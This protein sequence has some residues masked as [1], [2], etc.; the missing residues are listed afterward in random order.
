MRINKDQISFSRWKNFKFSFKRAHSHF[1]SYLLNRFRWHYYPRW[2]LVSRFPSHLDIE[3]SSVCNMQCPMCFTIT[4]DFKTKIDK[5]FMSFSLFKKIV[6][7]A[8][9][10]KTYSVRI[11]HRGEPFIHPEVIDFIKYAKENGIKEVSSL[12]NILALSPSLFEQ[13]MKAGLDWLTISFDGLGDTYEAIRKPAKFKESYEK[14]KEYKRIKEEAKSYK[15]V[16]KIQSIWP[17]IRDYAEEYIKSFEPYVDTI[18]SNPLIDY[19]HKDDPAKIEYWEDFDCP[20]PYQR[21]TI[22]SNGLVPYCH[23]DEF[24]TSIVGDIKKETIYN[25]WNGK[26]MKKVREAHKRNNG[27]T[28]LSACKH[29]FL[30]RK[31]KPV[32]EHIGNKKIIVEKYTKRTEEIGA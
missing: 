2:H 31:V 15:P 30:P 12:S 14:I 3:T 24:N 18:A 19:L 29:C 22:L 23:N 10:H 26:K 25:I 28:E 9:K 13:A 5:E 20:T 4:K 8:V 1:T 16:I 17:A 32:V 7:E 6:D 11:S 27:V 21:L